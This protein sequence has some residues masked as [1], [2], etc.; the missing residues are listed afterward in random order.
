MGKVERAAIDD[1]KDG[2]V[3]IAPS[4]YREDPFRHVRLLKANR[5][6][7]DTA[8]ALAKRGGLN[9]P[10]G[11]P[12]IKVEFSPFV[13]PGHV[14]GFDGGGKMVIMIGPREDNLPTGEETKQ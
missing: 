2:T 14:V 3:A 6:L 9:K 11:F 10:A 13:P 5:D 12:A 7:Y 1:L 4:E 8:L